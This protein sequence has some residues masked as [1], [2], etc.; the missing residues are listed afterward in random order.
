VEAENERMVGD[1]VESE[2]ACIN[3]VKELE[4]MS[5]AVTAA[6]KDLAGRFSE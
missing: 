5:S 1:I 3:A 4:G 6:A 2:R